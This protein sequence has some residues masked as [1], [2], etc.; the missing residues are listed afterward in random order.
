MKELLAEIERV[1]FKLW[2][3]VPLSTLAK[4]LRDVWKE[5]ESEKA[6]LECPRC[7]KLY[8]IEEF[9]D[10]LWCTAC[11]ANPSGVWIDRQSNAVNDERAEAYLKTLMLNDLKSVA[12]DLTTIRSNID[13]LQRLISDAFP[14]SSSKL[15]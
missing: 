13:C 14:A 9:M 5:H 7:G 10:G 6:V 2:S 8:A 4:R 12:E 3:S 1:A 15:K 11:A